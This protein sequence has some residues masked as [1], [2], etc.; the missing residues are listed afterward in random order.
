LGE[1]VD[2]IT[3]MV[4]SKDGQRLE[5]KLAAIGFRAA[6]AVHYSRRR[7]LADR[8]RLIP[9]GDGVPRLTTEALREL[10]LRFVPTGISDMTYRIDVEGMGLEEGTPEFAA[11]LPN[12]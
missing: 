8:P 6:D 9:V 11:V 3:A 7:R 5:S 12:V 4:A 1:T 2:R 10:P